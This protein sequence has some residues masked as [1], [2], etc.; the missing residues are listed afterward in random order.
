[1]GKQKRE[2]LGPPRFRYIPSFEAMLRNVPAHY[3][4]K[5]YGHTCFWCGVE[6]DYEA[7]PDAPTKATR[8]H[9]IPASMGG[10]WGDN[11]VTACLRCNNARGNSL[12]WVLY[13]IIRQHPLLDARPGTAWLR[14]QAHTHNDCA[15]CS[16]AS[17]VPILLKV[18]N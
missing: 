12:E 16:G 17:V 18:K 4:W 9:L 11:I 1:M 14:C 6:V 8:E 7:V 5:F 15:T 2:R 13:Y 3:L 10:G